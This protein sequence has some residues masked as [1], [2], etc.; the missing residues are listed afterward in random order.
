VRPVRRAVRHPRTVALAAAV[1][2]GTGAPAVAPAQDA[3][4]DVTNVGYDRGDPR[5][6][7]VIVEFGDFACSACGLFARETLPAL[8]REYIAAGTVRIKYINFLLG[9]FRN[10]QGAALAAEC[11]A[12][13]DAFWSMHDVLYQRQREWTGALSP[14]AHFDGFARQ[15]GLDLTRFG[16]CMDDNRHGARILANTEL[17]RRLQIRATPTFFINGMRVQGAI[18]L[19]SMRTIVQALMQ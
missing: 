4:I 17:A 18:P 11:A 16:R 6:A 1:L 10:A 15:L 7:I 9:T 19:E 12:D 14:R 2:L 5:A 13:Q 8:Y 3:S